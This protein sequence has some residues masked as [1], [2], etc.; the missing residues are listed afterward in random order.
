LIL[1]KCAFILGLVL[2][3]GLVVDDAIVVVEAVMHNIEHGMTPKDATN[4]AMKEVGGPVGNC[5][6]SFGSIH[7][8]AFTELPEDCTSSLLL[9]L[10]FQFASRLL[11]RLR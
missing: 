5:S 2:A 10:L 11:M 6:Y 1:S 4:K 3:I 8:V 7:P 9:P